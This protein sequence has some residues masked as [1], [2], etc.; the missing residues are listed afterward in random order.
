MHPVLITVPRVVLL[1]S[2]GLS[3]GLCG[4]QLF[5]LGRCIQTETPPPQ[6]PIERVQV[7]F[8]GH[9]LV[10]RLGTRAWP[11]RRGGA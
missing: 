11:G 9:G 8:P 4:K 3:N 1:V 6:A 2:L 10:A 5:L 7:L